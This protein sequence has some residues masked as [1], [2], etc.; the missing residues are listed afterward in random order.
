M[1]TFFRTHISH[2]SRSG[3]WGEQRGVS[4]QVLV[5]GLHGGISSCLFQEEPG[6]LLQLLLAR[7]HLLGEGR[8]ERTCT[9]SV[10]LKLLGLQYPLF[11][12]AESKYPLKQLKPIE[13]IPSGLYSS[14][15]FVLCYCGERFFAENSRLTSLQRVAA[16]RV[17]SLSSCYFLQKPF[18]QKEYCG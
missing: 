5:S 13:R 14:V 17:V 9:R 3:W 16:R 1:H 2:V 18:P 12:I 15:F 11:L 8:E 4:S 10:V 7:L 6:S